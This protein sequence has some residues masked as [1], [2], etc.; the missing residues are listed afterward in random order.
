MSQVFDGKTIDD[1][2]SLT[3][4]EADQGTDRV[5]V[6]RMLEFNLGNRSSTN[7]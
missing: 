6:K 5:V 4:S 1:T 2:S 3:V 7:K